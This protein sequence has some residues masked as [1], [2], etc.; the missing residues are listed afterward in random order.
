[1]NI[2]LL[3]DSCIDEYHYGKTRLSPEA[4]VPIFNLESIETK[5]GMG[6]NVKNNLVKLGVNVVSYFGK[7]SLKKRI[8]DKKTNKQICRIDED[9]ISNSLDIKVLLNILSISYFD[10]IVISDYNKGFIN[11]DVIKCIQENTNIPIFIDTKKRDLNKITSDKTFFKI[12]ELEYNNLISYPENLIIT[13][14]SDSVL[15]KDIEIKVPKTEII[16]VCGAGD[17]FLSSLVFKYLENRDI[18]ESIKFAIAASSITIK[19]IGVYSPDL[20]NI[21]ETYETIR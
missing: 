14:A 15:Y 3:G 19:H 6:F 9:I 16:D 11:E 13:R 17:T 20:N 8:I 12:N 5:E 10:A 18:I 1:M 2:L 4:P 21:K 7:N